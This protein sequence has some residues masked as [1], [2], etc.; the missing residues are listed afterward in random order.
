MCLSGEG[1]NVF[2][3]R[4]AECV[5]KVDMEGDKKWVC[6][7]PCQLLKHI[8]P[9]SNQTRF[10]PLHSNTLTHS[11]T[12]QSNTFCPL[13]SNTFCYSPLKY[14][15]TPSTQSHFVSLHSN[16]FWHPPLKYILSLSTEIH[17]DTLH[18]N[19]FCHSA[20][21]NSLSLSTQMQCV[22]LQRTLLKT[23]CQSPLKHMGTPSTQS[24]QQ[25]MSTTTHPCKNSCHSPLRHNSPIK[26]S[27]STST[28]THS[29]NCNLYPSLSKQ[30]FTL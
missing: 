28:Q 1:Q 7:P 15:L 26:N 20:F 4:V 3:W 14:I 13:H 12:L 29:V 24:F 30:F 18:S 25:I 2:D 5:L 17:F 9:L 6:H 16:T 11:V 23:F 8:L 19:T 27:L 21:R 22:I 10:V